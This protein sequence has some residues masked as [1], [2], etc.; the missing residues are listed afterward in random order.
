MKY[1]Q[2]LFVLFLAATMACAPKMAKETTSDAPSNKDFRSMAPSPGPA[3]PI[4]I[5]KSNQFTLANGLKVIV[6]ENHKLPQI[7]YQLT[8]DR[9]E[10]MEKEKSGEFPNSC[11]LKKVL[12]K[13]PAVKANNI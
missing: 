7:S 2:F 10:M 9:D 1:F 8:I 6:V 13:M 12:K 4:E 3:R 5:G 11:I